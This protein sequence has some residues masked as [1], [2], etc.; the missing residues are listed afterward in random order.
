MKNVLVAVA[1]V[2]GLSSQVFAAVP[3]QPVS[4][5]K[6]KLTSISIQP[7]VPHKPKQGEYVIQPVL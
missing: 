3:S 2:F 6:T 1:L 7:V 4:S 5:E